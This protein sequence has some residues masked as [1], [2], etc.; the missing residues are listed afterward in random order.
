MGKFT[1]RIV[2]GNQKRSNLDR[3]GKGFSNFV[4]CGWMGSEYTGFSPILRDD[5]T[6]LLI[7]DVETEAKSSK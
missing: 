7:Q 2:A 1:N 6:I 3:G 4:E 5:A